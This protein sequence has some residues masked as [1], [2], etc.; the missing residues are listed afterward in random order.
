[1]HER[2]APFFY[3]KKI[4]CKLKIVKRERLKNIQRTDVN[5]IDNDKSTLTKVDKVPVM[6][7]TP[8]IVVPNKNNN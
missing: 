1:M 4:N 3:E 7:L 5:L 6:T 2:N 8:N